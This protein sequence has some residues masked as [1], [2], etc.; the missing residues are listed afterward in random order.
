GT[1]GGPI[2]ATYATGF[3][4]MDCLITGMN[5]WAGVQA[6]TCSRL[7]IINNDFRDAQMPDVNHGFGVA[8]DN[9]HHV[10]IQSN[11]FENYM[12]NLFS[13]KSRDG[14]FLNNVCVG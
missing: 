8:I 11:H 4:V 1:D 14:Y 7:R 6:K 10:L 3:T 13:N 5:N 9:S 2:E 12:E